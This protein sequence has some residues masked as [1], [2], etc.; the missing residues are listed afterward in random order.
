MYDPAMG[1][2]VAAVTFLLASTMACGTSD[3]TEP[4]RPAVGNLH[5]PWSP[6]PIALPGPIL[7]AIDAACRGSMQPFPV[8]VDLV[9][10]DARGLGVVQANYAG[11]NGAGATCVDMSID[12]GGRATASGGGSTGQGGGP[13]HAVAANTLESG[14]GMSSGQPVTSSV[15][16]GRAG[17]GIA[18]VAILIPGQ[19]LTTASFANGWYLA[20][21]PGAW[22]PGTTVLGLDALGQKVAEAMP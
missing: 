8:G 3:L 22:P 12:Q 13:P 17:P 21:F 16:L 11:P 20:W 7:Q 1:W 5:G 6:N 9:V 2:R 15:T 18:R 4:E 14:G 19:P 10:V